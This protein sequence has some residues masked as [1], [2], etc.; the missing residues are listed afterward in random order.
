MSSTSHQSTS[1]LPPNAENQSQPVDYNAIIEQIH[2]LEESLAKIQNDEQILQVQKTLSTLL[3]TLQS[4]VESGKRDEESVVDV[5]SVEEVDDL[6]TVSVYSSLSLSSA[7]S[8]TMS[9][10]YEW[11][12]E[13]ENGRRERERVHT[14]NELKELFDQLQQE[15]SSIS[16]ANFA[17]TS[18]SSKTMQDKDFEIL[19]I[20]TTHSSQH[21]EHNYEV[22]EV[23]EYEEQNP[24]HKLTLARLLGKLKSIL[25][26]ISRVIKEFI[27]AWIGPSE[28]SAS[29]S[30]TSKPSCKDKYE[31]DSL[32]EGA[33]SEIDEYVMNDGWMTTAANCWGWGGSS[34]RR[35]DGNR[36]AFNYLHDNTKFVFSPNHN[37]YM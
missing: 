25:R 20:S 10:I 30:S 27:S 37:F 18:S 19:K 15:S 35:N 6:S 23:E 8:M 12:Q 22:E 4:A 17:I 24:K 34:S 7:C 26:R 33:W 9:M 21:D 14:Y 31:C 16:S 1:K 28:N 3:Y 2:T 13:W 29:C 32:L 36:D 11:M 5:E